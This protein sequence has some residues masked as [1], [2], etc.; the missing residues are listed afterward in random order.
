MEFNFAQVFT[1][2]V[3]AEPIV[4]IWFE[5]AAPIEATNVPAA[6]ETAPKKPCTAP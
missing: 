4:P 6:L 3:T 5:T 2:V 1:T